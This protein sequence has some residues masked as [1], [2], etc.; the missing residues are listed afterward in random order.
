MPDTGPSV[1][2]APITTNVQPT[3]TDKLIGAA[4]FAVTN[5]AT[6]AAPMMPGVHQDIGGLAVNS[7][8][9]FIN[10]VI[11]QLKRHDWFVQ[12]RVAI[13]TGVILAG[14]LCVAVWIATN[15]EAALVNFTNVVGLVLTNYGTMSK[16]GVIAAAGTNVIPSPDAIPQVEPP[17]A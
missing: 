8:A 4:T 15:P 2:A 12:D 16:T 1:P 7:F 13:W 9:L 6:I 3:N 10:A 11:Q 17:P 5:A 14:Y